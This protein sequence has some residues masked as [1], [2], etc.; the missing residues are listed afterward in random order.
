MTPIELSGYSVELLLDHRKE[1]L[2]LL[3]SLFNVDVHLRGNVLHLEGAEGDV[4]RVGKILDD[5]S[6]LAGE[7][8]NLDRDMLRRALREI[9]EDSALNLADFFPLTRV[10]HGTLGRRTHCNVS[11]LSR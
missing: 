1:S 6:R 9:A 10:I 2:K 8:Q 5:F 7:G 3:E 4:A 11:Q